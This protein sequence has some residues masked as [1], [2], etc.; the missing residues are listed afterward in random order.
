MARVHTLMTPYHSLIDIGG[1][2]S[3]MVV[4][5]QAVGVKR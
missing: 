4:A 2:L 3:V 1:A 5:V